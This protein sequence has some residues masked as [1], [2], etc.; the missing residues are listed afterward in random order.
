MNGK[1]LFIEIKVWQDQV[2]FQNLW[3]HISWCYFINWIFILFD[4]NANAKY[5]LKKRI[6]N[7]LTTCLHL[8]FAADFVEKTLFKKM[9]IRLLKS[10]LNQR[11]ENISQMIMQEMLEVDDQL[12]KVTRS[13]MD[14][15]GEVMGSNINISGKGHKVKHG[16]LTRGHE[17][18][19]GF[20]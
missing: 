2:S 10:S 5:K 8:Q 3:L 4:Q 17:V 11:K 19:Y 16:F 13:N 1:I 9:M 20:L 14:I 12:L 18:K 15:S 6:I 7:K